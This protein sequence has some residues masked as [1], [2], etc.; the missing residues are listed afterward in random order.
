M[1]EWQGYILI[2]GLYMF[3]SYYIYPVKSKVI[4]NV[5]SFIFITI[6]FCAYILSFFAIK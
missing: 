1:T 5:L 3:M 6:S 2:G 4:C